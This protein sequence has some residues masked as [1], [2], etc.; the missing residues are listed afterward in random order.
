M[1]QSDTY[2]RCTCVEVGVKLN[3]WGD[4]NFLFLIFSPEYEYG[5]AQLN[6][7]L[8]ESLSWSSMTS[9][10]FLFELVH[11]NDLFCDE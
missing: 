8:F 5:I 3:F 11:L 1:A 2:G 4:K 9:I 10:I 6:L 7:S